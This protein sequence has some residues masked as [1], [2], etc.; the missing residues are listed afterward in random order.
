MPKDLGVSTRKNFLGE[1]YQ[2][3]K[4]CGAAPNCFCSTDF[5]EEDPEHSIPSWTWPSSL[6]DKTAA[7]REIKSVI[8]SYKP[9]QSNIDGGGFQI[10][11]F[12]DD[13]G[14]VYV[15]FESI[16]HGYIDDFEMAYIND[17]GERS[18][19]LRS[20][21]RVGYLDFGVNAKRINYIAD[22]LRRKGWDAPGVDFKT[23]PDYA[24]QNQVL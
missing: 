4:P 10:V 14:Y 21:S 12:D 2:G 11:T 16:K 15:Q 17:K 22:A 19:Q 6:P 1:E 3:L 24:I 18:L 8:E 23:H 13:A 5:A 7:F 9:G 20:S